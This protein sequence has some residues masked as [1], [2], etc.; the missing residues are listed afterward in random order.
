MP[1]RPSPNITTGNLP[2]NTIETGIKAGKE[3]GVAGVITGNGTATTV[4]STGTGAMAGNGAVH[5]ETAITIVI[6]G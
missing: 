1:A 2:A 5:E 3:T 6:S 4:M